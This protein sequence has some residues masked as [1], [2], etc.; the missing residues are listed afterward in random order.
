MKTRATSMAFDSKLT[1]FMLN[2]E[3]VSNGAR[4]VA[5]EAVGFGESPSWNEVMEKVVKGFL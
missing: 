1:G 4:A 5:Y 2:G 3:V